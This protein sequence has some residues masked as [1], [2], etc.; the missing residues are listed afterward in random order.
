MLKID[1]EAEINKAI[2]EKNRAASEKKNIIKIKDVEESSSSS[3]MSMYSLDSDREDLE[4]PSRRSP[5]LIED[6]LPKN[7]EEVHS[8]PTTE[9][10]LSKRQ[11]VI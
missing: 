9:K 10:V 4:V 11:S 3:S 6:Q 5:T 1:K 2:V 7:Q 8:S